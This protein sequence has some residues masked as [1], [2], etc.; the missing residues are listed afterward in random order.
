MARETLKAF[1]IAWRREARLTASEMTVFLHA[2]VDPDDAEHE[3]ARMHADAHGDG[4]IADAGPVHVVFDDFFLHRYGRSYRLVR[5]LIAGEEGHDTVADV[6]VHETAMIGHDRHHAREI[7]VDESEVLLDRELLGELGEGPDVGEEYRHLLFH[8]VAQAQVD[9]VVLVEAFEEFAGD[10]ALHRR[11][12]VGDVVREI[13]RGFE[14]VPDF[15]H[16]HEHGDEGEEGEAGRFDED[17]GDEGGGEKTM[18]ADGQRSQEKG[19]AEPERAAIALDREDGD[20]H[21]D[22]DY[23]EGDVGGDDYVE[24]GLE[25]GK[26]EEEG[27]GGGEEEGG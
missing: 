5:A 15:F 14:A 4:A 27:R 1:V 22:D 26:I 18:E 3:I 8:M 17:G 16:E 10:E 21:D 19:G 2:V 13:L 11:G 12:D 25:V 7:G 20:P 6:L 9:D 23:E 24:K